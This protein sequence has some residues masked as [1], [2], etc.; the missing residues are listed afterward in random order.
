MKHAVS[1]SK[2]KVVPKF[3]TKV[4]FDAAGLIFVTNEYEKRQTQFLHN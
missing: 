4:M 3:A 1:T 2:K